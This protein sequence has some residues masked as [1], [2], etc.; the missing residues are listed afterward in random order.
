[1]HETIIDIETGID[2]VRD[3]LYEV[4]HEHEDHYV[5]SNRYSTPCGIGKECEG[6]KYTVITEE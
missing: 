4:V 1:M 6:E 2:F 5:V 3:R